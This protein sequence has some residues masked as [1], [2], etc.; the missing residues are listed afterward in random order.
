M[1]AEAAQ[2]ETRLLPFDFCR[3]DETSDG[4]ERPN[5][6]AGVPVAGIFTAVMTRQRVIRHLFLGDEERD[7]PLDP[8]R[9]IFPGDL[10]LFASLFNC[11]SLF[12]SEVPAEKDDSIGFLWRQ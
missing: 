5:G 6:Q 7:A 11:H 1:E 3:Q 12:R 2:A 10:E 4:I 8:D 9:G